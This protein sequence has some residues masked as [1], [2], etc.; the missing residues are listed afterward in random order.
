MAFRHIAKLIVGGLLASVISSVHAGETLDRVM[1]NKVLV[2]VNDQAYPPFSFIDDSGEVVGFDIDISR[3]FAKRLGVDF[4]VE[5]PSWEIITAGNWHGRWDICICSMSPTAE[6]AQVLSFVNEY[7]GA[8]VVIAVNADNTSIKSAKDL[9]D[10]KVGVQ[11]G[12]PYEKYLQKQLVNEVPGK[13]PVT[14]DFPFG[15]ITI[16]PYDT[17]DFAFQDLGLGDGKRLDAV[18]AGYMTV[19][20][21]VKKSEGK[22]KIVGDDLFHE[23]LLVA[24]DK[25]DP[26]W[27]AKIREI[28]KAMYD[29]GTLKK[30]SE[31][32]VGRDITLKQ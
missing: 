26:E 1:K 9:T 30:I 8:P 13:P 16:Q 19:S 21:R 18:I 10:K 22:L 28:F 23:S 11:A 20:E 4:K 5:T 12:T 25:G 3:E 24:V 14:P 32:W 29:D 17:E 27:E 7:Y 6:R 2:E 15:D 31:K